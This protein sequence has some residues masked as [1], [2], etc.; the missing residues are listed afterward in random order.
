MPDVL[1]ELPPGLVP[2][3]LFLTSDMPR[4]VAPWLESLGD[5]FLAVDPEGPAFRAERTWRHIAA[6]PQ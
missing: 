5:V 1:M 3:E 4:R 6:D 2:V